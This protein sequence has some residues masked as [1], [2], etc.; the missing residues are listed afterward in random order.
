[1]ND[2]IF[3]RPWPF[4]VAGIAIGLFVP[5]F[6]WISGKSLGISSGYAELCSLG[7]PAGKGRWKLWFV[8]GLPLGGL[9]ASVLAGTVHVTK[10]V[11][12]MRSALGVTTG[13]QWAMFALGGALIGWGARAAGGCTSG[14]S[15]VG[16]ALGARSSLVAT[17]GFMAGGFAA[18]WG[19][20]ALLGGAR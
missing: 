13:A 4:W 1:M 17:L 15:I 18:T 2:A 20:W 9:L 16:L 11:E 14:H 3:V 10:S 7:A 12:T 8:L 19:A 6:A 5:L